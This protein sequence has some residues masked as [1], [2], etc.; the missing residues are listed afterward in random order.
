MGESEMTTPEQIHAW[1]REARL[2]D[3]FD[4]HSRWEPVLIK[5]TELARADLVAEVERLTTYNAT[6]TD[7]LAASVMQCAALKAENE[8]LKAACDKYSE[9]DILMPYQV[10]VESLRKD[11]EQ[12]RWLCDNN[13]S[14]SWTP[15]RFSPGLISGFS[16]N[17]TG[18]LGFNFADAVTKA[19][20]E[21]K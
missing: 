15:S 5:Y 21:T 14:F 10:E 18:Y 2:M 13:K 6:R 3:E 1:A 16:F 17:G 11:A 9:A 4:F 8:R 12:Y 20:E 19:M 7:E